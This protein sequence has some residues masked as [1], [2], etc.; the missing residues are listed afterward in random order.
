[1]ADKEILQRLDR[2]I[3]ILQLANHADIEEG[4]ERI[5]AD[6]LNAAILEAAVKEIAA[7]KLI[8]AAKRGAKGSPSKPT[9]RRRI[10]ALVDQGA[11]ER[12][13]AG[14]ATRY[15]VTGLV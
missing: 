13:G 14:P 4:R 5:R 12:I 7:G 2:I 15:K 8:E 10:A 1:M 3:A 9:I 6:D 11:L